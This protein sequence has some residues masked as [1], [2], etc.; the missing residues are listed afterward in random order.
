MWVIAFTT[1]VSKFP[2]GCVLYVI[3]LCWQCPPVAKFE[4]SLL[5]PYLCQTIFMSTV[6]ILA[7]NI[8]IKF[9]GIPFF[10]GHP[11]FQGHHHFLG[12]SHYFWGHSHYWDLF[13]FKAVLHFEVFYIFGTNYQ[14]CSWSSFRQ[15]NGSDVSS[16]YFFS[17]FFPSLLFFLCCLA[18]KQI[19]SYFSHTGCPRNENELIMVQ[20]LR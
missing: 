11:H 18:T 8:P 5:H 19:K 9:C 20:K 4:S 14:H 2:I 15:L 10:W 12:H 3:C 17:F 16:H 6:M 1:T 7:I 13:I